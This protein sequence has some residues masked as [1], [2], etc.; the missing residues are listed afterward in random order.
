MRN[1]WSIDDLVADLRPVR[2]RAPW[3]D[4]AVLAGVAGV[5]LA[6]WLLLG[7]ARPDLAEASHGP[8][9]FWKL[10]G[11]L[12]V[13][14]IGVAT[15]LASLTPERSPRIGLR[16]VAVA[17]GLALLVGGVLGAGVA[18]IADAS[19][20]LDWRHGLDCIGAMAGLSILPAVAFALLAR[21]GAPTD[22]GGTALAGGLWAAAWGAF[23]FAFACPSDDPFYIAFW[24]GAGCG[25]IALVARS[26][27]A[28]VT[29]W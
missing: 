4:A 7:F 22:I 9:L 10:G 20:R 13:A 14:L 12:L 18:S 28:R 15:A 25:G 11:L 17:A 1:E 19:A 24:Y 3:R 29:R 2:R 23:V 27:I 16:G 26:A 8:S 5:E 21:R 6:I